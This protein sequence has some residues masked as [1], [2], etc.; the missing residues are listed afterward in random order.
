MLILCLFRLQNYPPIISLSTYSALITSPSHTPLSLHPLHILRSNYIPLHI[1]RSN[2]IPPSPPQG[3][4]CT[5][6]ISKVKISIRKYAEYQQ[7][8]STLY[9]SPLEGVGGCN[10]C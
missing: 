4:S 10:E 1:L 8:S 2:Y 9:N 6:E 3:G 7:V 5:M